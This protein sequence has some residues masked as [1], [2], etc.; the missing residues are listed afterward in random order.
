MSLSQFDA[1]WFKSSYSQAG[2][3]CVEVAFLSAG[4]VGIRDS[5]DAA[6][7]A[8]IFS[9]HDWTAFTTSITGGTFDL[10]TA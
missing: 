4:M 6:G 5:K 10:P 2:G 1:R 3:E 9:P 8:L 7:P